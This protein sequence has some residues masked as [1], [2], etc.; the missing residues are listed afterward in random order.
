MHATKKQRGKKENGEIDQTMRIMSHNVEK[1]HVVCLSHE[2]EKV[3]RSR[4]G[5]AKCRGRY[6]EVLKVKLLPARDRGPWDYY[7]D[8]DYD[9]GGVRLPDPA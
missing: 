7:Y 9:C 1:Q 4:E 8:Y 3:W 6:G 5:M 2:V